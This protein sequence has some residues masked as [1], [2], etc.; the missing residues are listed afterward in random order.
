MKKQPKGFWKIIKHINWKE[1]H[2]RGDNVETAKER[3]LEKVSPQSIDFITDGEGLTLEEFQETYEELKELIN[4]ETDRRINAKLDSFAKNVSYGAD[5][6]HFMDLPAHLIGL[7]RKAVTDYLN[8]GLVKHEVS[9][10][11][12]YIFHR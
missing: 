10:C 4:D 7:G 2:D 6:C 1:I 11:L 9:E 8:G 5:D 3:M 12:S